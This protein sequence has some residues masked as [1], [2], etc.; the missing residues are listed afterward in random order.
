MRYRILTAVVLTALAALVLGCNSPE[1]TATPLPPTPQKINPT[2]VPKPTDAP[3]PPTQPPA[4]TA[5]PAAAA[6][7]TSAP[8]PTTAAPAPTTAPA[9]PNV[10]PPLANYFG[11]STNGEVIYNDEI[12]AQA[13]LAGVQL[14]RT[15]IDWNVIEA[16]KGKY[17]WSYSRDNFDRLLQNNI[18]PLVLILQN[19]TWAANTHCGPVDD[20]EGF[21]KFLRA[22]VA[23]YPE[24]MYWALSN[25][26]DDA[27]YP[28]REGAGCYGSGDLNGNGKPDVQDYAEQLRIAWKAVHETNPR[29]KLLSGAVAFDNFDEATVPPGYPGAGKGGKFNANFIPDLFAYMQAHPLSNGEKYFDIFAFNYYDIYGQYWQ[30]QAEGKGIT[31]KANKIKALMRQAGIDAP[32]LVGETGEDSYVVGNDK[33][34]EFL[35]KTLTR[36]LATDVVGV[37]WWTFQDF[38]DSAPPP[39][40]T[41][42][43][44]LLDQTAA[45]KPSFAAYQTTVRE[46]T[47]STFKQA[48][49]VDGGEGYLFEKDGGG[50]AVV[51]SATDDP[52]VVAFAANRLKVVELYGAA[53][54]VADGSAQDKDAAPGRIGLQVGAAP[55]FVQVAGQ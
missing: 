54:E 25:E 40:N 30:T 52:V 12:R 13:V 27:G 48:L 43:Y 50:K 45:P 55:V 20:L 39:S 2:A 32:L 36:A 35:V 10:V 31:A 34:S 33:Q 41:W 22:A 17:K 29:A 46:L 9:A 6:V 3:A 8:A 1:P 21:D 28:G 44:G 23:Q 16:E 38:P 42:K 7:P 47:G 26:P 15:S 5:V 19:P 53:T 24:V 18:A 51:W 49:N 4:P 11:A 37:I 14:L